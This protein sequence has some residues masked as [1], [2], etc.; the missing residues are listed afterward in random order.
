[1]TEY[2]DIFWTVC[3]NSS[4]SGDSSCSIK[5]VAPNTKMYNHN[6]DDDHVCQCLDTVT[7]MN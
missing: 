5:Q 4:S 3:S 1:L 6:E 7:E 2:W